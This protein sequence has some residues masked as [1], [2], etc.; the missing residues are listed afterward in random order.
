MKTF[1]HLEAVGDDND[2]PAGEL[3]LEER[4]EKWL[5]G[6]ANLHARQRSANFQSPGEGAHSGKL[7]EVSEQ[8]ACRRH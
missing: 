2:G 4:R 3:L 6:R 7:R 5:G 8:I 1:L